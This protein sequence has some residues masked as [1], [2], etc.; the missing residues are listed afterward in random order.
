MGFA[1]F[2]GNPK[3]VERLRQKLRENHFPQSLIFAGPEGVGKRTFALMVA[4]ALNCTNAGPADF[5]DECSQCRKIN[6]GTHPDVFTITV[7]EE[8]TQIKIAQ[9]RRVLEVLGMQPLEGQNKVFIIEPA[10]L[11]NEGSANALLKGL[12][13]PPDNSFFILLAV[14]VH[15]LLLTIRSRC[16]VYHFSPLSFEEVRRHGV[17]DE[18]AVRWS[19]GSIGKA[20]NFDIATVKEQ[21]DVVLEFIETA[22]HAKDETLR[23]M[24]N[25]SAELSRT[26]QDFSGYLGVMAVLLGDILYISEGK[27]D[28]VINIDIRQRLDSVAQAAP[29]E[30]WI[31]VAEFLRVMESSLKGHINKQMLT[32]AMALV[33]AEISNDIST[34]SR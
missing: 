26:R 27:T 14:N 18:L 30:R 24:L 28:R 1:S 22:V 25:A 7:E 11:M 31:R 29:T 16:Q 23:E 19:Q 8:A 10:N 2:I 15:E 12:E 20:L 13:E 34:K 33:T 3:V 4:K 9:I 17:S 32:D 21:R 6:S 5:C